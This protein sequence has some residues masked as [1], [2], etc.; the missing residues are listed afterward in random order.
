M[1]GHNLKKFGVYFLDNFMLVVVAQWYAQSSNGC[2][3]YCMW[4][5]N[6]KTGYFAEI[7]HFMGA[8]A[9]NYFF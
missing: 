5:M 6:L 1:T 8:A 4:Q 9:S 3:Q 7:G 2:V